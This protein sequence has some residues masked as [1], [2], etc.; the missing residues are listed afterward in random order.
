MNKKKIFR[1]NKLLIN[2]WIFIL[3]ISFSSGIVIFSIKT[4]LL[5]TYWHDENS[6]VE[7]A[8]RFGSGNLKP[9]T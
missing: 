4:N 9:H 6:F 1:I 8:L 7:T 5:Y 3:I 2:N